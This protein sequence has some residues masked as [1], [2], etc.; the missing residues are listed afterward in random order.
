[1]EIVVRSASQQWG[2]VFRAGLPQYEFVA[3]MYAEPEAHEYLHTWL[4]M[5]YQMSTVMPDLD[6]MGDWYTALG[7]YVSRNHVDTPELSE[8]EMQ[9]LNLAE[10]ERESFERNEAA[11]YQ[12]ALDELEQ[13]KAEFDAS[14]VSEID[15]IESDEEMDK[16]S[17]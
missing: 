2:M 12:A 3:R 16:S 14:I 1:M 11:M 8:D 9:E 6:L 15:A 5:V 4:C 10:H 17:E 7:A 13:N